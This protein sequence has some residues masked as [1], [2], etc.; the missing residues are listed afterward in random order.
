MNHG[1]CP[2]YSTRPFGGWI[3]KKQQPEAGV[4]AAALG[5]VL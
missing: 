1:V 5:F 3:K 2:I 4:Y